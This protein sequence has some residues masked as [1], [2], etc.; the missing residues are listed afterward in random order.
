MQHAQRDVGKQERLHL[1]SFRWVQGNSTITTPLETTSQP[2]QPA[3]SHSRFRQPEK[4]KP[5]CTAVR[6]AY[7][8]WPSH[9]VFIDC[10]LFLLTIVFQA[11]SMFLRFSP[12]FSA[13]CV[14]AL[15]HFLRYDCG[16]QAIYKTPCSLLDFHTTC[17]LA[18]I[19]S[20]ISSKCSQTSSTRKR[21]TR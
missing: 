20:R 12:K 9:R 13:V 2:L 11:Y 21:R 19:V 6:I 7:N 14:R 16:C 15:L 3:K 18:S 1:F 8:W 4:T 5:P 17:T 10:S